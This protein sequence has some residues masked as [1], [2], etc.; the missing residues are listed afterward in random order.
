MKVIWFGHS[1][2][3]VEFGSHV[4]LIDPFLSGNPGFKGD[5]AA[6]TAGVTHIL[7]SHGHDDHVGDTVEISKTTGA[8]VVTNF[9]LSM[10][11]LEKGVKNINP[12]NTG[13]E[14]SCGDFSVTLT[15]AQH[16]SSTMLDGKPV[17]LGNPNGLIIKHAGSPTLYH[18]G[19]T[20]I[21]SDMALI[22]ELHAPEIVLIPIGDRFTMGARTA[23][24]ALNR[25]LKPKVAIP[26]HYASFDM[27]AANAG[28]FQAEMAE[29]LTKVLVPKVGEVLIF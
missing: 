27:V 26:M 12:G 21:F 29:S 5:I 20:E 9:D 24:L 22:A 11:L 15:Y 28:P 16:S 8:Q 25:Y 13:G 3:R 18:M 19:D 6:A 4:L 17:F 23:A 2:F 10:Y 14:I 7:L 1:A